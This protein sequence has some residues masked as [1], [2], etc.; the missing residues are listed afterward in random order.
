M[1]P[2]Q[3]RGHDRR[4][5]GSVAV[6]ARKDA[7]SVGLCGIE[8]GW[9]EWTTKRSEVTCSECKREVERRLERRR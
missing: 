4:Y 8:P 6:H 3:H 1:P 7:H 5:K 9:G 2:E